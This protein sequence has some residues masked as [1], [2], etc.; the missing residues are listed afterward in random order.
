[1]TDFAELQIEQL[2]GTAAGRKAYSTYIG[3]LA[4]AVADVLRTRA[5]GGGGDPRREA[6]TPWAMECALEPSDVM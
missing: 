5:G 2:V 1:M 4:E 3:L 6:A